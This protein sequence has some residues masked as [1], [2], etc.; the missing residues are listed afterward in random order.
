MPD[1]PSWERKEP[2]SGSEVAWSFVSF[3]GFVWRLLAGLFSRDWAPVGTQLYKFKPCSHIPLDRL[4]ISEELEKSLTILM[5]P[6]SLAGFHGAFP[7]AIVPQG[8]PFCLISWGR[9]SPAHEFSHP[10]CTLWVG[11]STGHPSG[12][13]FVSHPFTPKVLQLLSVACRL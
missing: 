2:W 12:W 13:I 1:T 4:I 8:E 6:S 9:L 7:T 3:G 5:V 10:T 11:E